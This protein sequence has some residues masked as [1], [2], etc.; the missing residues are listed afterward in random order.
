MNRIPTLSAGQNYCC[1]WVPCFLVSR[2]FRSLDEFFFCSIY[3]VTRY[4]LERFTRGNNVLTLDN[5]Y[6]SLFERIGWSLPEVY[7][8]L[9]VRIGLFCPKYICPCLYGLVCFVQIKC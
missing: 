5:E 8:S 1:G 4:Q 7:I 3:E 2:P 6:I 9:F